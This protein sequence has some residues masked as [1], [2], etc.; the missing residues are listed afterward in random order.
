[1]FLPFKSVKQYIPFKNIILT[2]II[3][4]MYS[5]CNSANV[6]KY[7]P[8]FRPYVLIDPGVSSV[9]VYVKR[10]RLLILTASLD[11][12]TALRLTI[13]SNLLSSFAR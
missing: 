2:S 1:M 9:E 13:L 11:E 8:I 12:N 4:Y 7:T 10:K 6:N 5:I 3:A